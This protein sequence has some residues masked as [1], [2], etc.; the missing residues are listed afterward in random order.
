MA[1]LDKCTQ[2]PEHAAITAINQFFPTVGE[3]VLVGDRRR[4][5]PF[6]LRHH[7]AHRNW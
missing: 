2:I 5:P 1:G 3:T 6:V 7:L 4:L